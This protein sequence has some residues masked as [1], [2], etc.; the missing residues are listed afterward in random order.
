MCVID[1]VVKRQTFTDRHRYDTSHSRVPI[2]TRDRT[3]FTELQI[4]ERLKLLSNVEQIPHVT[5]RQQYFATI[6]GF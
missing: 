1:A 6:Q 5:K 3:L 2:N 4:G